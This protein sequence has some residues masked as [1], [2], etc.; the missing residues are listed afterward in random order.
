[1]SNPNPFVTT[2]PRSTWRKPKKR[3]R[4]KVLADVQVDGEAK[5]YSFELRSDGLHVR[6]KHGWRSREKVWKFESLANGVAPG[7][8]QMKLI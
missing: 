6:P 2:K 4:G 3:L 8:A 7:Q 5:L 1:M